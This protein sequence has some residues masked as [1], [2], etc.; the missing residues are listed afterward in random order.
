MLLTRVLTALVLMPLMLAAI[1]LLPA[2]LFALVMAFMVVLGAWEWSDLVAFK[3][4]RLPYVLFVALAL[5][6]LYRLP[7]AL[8]PMLWLSAAWWLLAF[9]LIRYYPRGLPLWQSRPVRALM[10]LLVLL[11]MWLALLQL[12]A[13]D[14]G[15]WLVLLLMLFVWSADIGAYF[16][17]RRW[18]NAKLA[19]NVS[20]GKTWAGVIGAVVAALLLALLSGSWFADQYQWNPASWLLWGVGTVLW[21]WVSVVGDL[22]ESMLKRFRGIKDS[23]QLLPGHGG[24]LDRIDSLTAAAP[25]FLLWLA[26]WPN[27]I[28]NVL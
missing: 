10:G 26:L 19:P 12:R 24:V 4:G 1:F 3:R 5:L 17:G 15:P 13:H 21:V 2:P 7:Q 6:A 27:L 14:L 16:S 11:P 18:G 20:P 8:V 22:F 28:P 23:S 25:L 9:V